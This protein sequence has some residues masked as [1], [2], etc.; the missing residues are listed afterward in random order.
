MIQRH[1][2]SFGNAGAAPPACPSFSFSLK[3]A[4][5][6]LNLRRSVASR[7]CS[8]LRP[9]SWSTFPA[10]SLLPENRDQIQV[11]E[12]LRSP[13]SIVKRWLEDGGELCPNLLRQDGCRALWR[14]LN[15][16]L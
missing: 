16:D 5:R 2:S 9:D 15:Q 7:G 6:I 8:L 12:T 14:R 1:G 3:I 10:L 13:H 11:P 4:L